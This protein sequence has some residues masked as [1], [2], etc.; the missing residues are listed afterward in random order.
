[1]TNVTNSFTWD[2]LCELSEE[3]GNNLLRFYPSG[4]VPSFDVLL[5]MRDTADLSKIDVFDGSFGFSVGA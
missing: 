5:A 2:Q 1:M 3:D 4:E